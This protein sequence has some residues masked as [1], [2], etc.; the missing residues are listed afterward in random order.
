MITK[1]ELKNKATEL[2][3]GPVNVQRDYVFGWVLFGIFTSPALKDLLIL[4]GGNCLRK[5]YFEFTRFSSDLDFATE[6]AVDPAMLKEELNKV[7]GVVE[8]MSGVKFDV[9]ENRVDEGWSADKDQHVYKARLYFHDFF[10]GRDEMLITIRLDI[11]EFDK[12]HL[13]LQTRKLIHS[14]SDHGVCSV[15]MRCL[16]LEETLGTKLKCLLQ[17]KHIADLYDFVYSIFIRNEIDINRLQ[18]AEVF[19]KKT[20]FQPSPRAA[21]SILV[22]LPLDRLEDAWTRFIVCPKQSILDFRT[23]ISTFKDLVTELFSG[24]PNRM[25]ELAFF[26][27]E[28][29]NPIM[30]AGSSQTLLR[31]RYN[32]ADRLIEPYALS[33]KRRKDGVAREYLFVHDLTGGTSG[34]T[35]IKSFVASGFQ[36]IENTDQKFEPREEIL[37]SKAGEQG[38]KLY[39]GN[40]SP[41]YKQPERKLKS[42]RP[43]SFHR[44]RWIYTVECP[45]CQR[46][47]DR[48]TRTTALR[49]HQ[50]GYGNR[51]YGKRG[52]IVDQKFA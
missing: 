34:T 9:E 19:L 51:C 40:Q 1:A 46:K 50:D 4:K 35:G 44:A 52:Y 41:Y 29:R 22:G 10:G 32:N 17:R 38:D 47:F 48:T 23:T 30:E 12:I 15:E 24:L 21:A 31:V 25:S 14:Y 43:R 37:I 5:A 49:P 18:V 36:F 26:P 13:P 33:F 27:P 16:S 39:F 42:T 2:A 3:V 45:V 7:C 8:S 6:A 20:I 11:S 28:L